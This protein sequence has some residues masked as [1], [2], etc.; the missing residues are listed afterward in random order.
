M[1]LTET[2]PAP[3]DTPPPA[4]STRLRKLVLAGLA[5]AVLVVFGILGFALWTNSKIDRLDA[6]ALPSLTPALGDGTRTFLVVGTDDRSD[7]PEDFA[8]VFGEFGGSRTDTI[9]LVNFTPGRGAEVIS[10]PRDLRVEIPGEGTNRINAAFSLGGPELLIATISD[11]LD[12]DVN[13]YVEIDLAGFAR[14]VDAIDGV[15]LLFEHDARDAKSGLAVTAGLQRL[16]GEQALAYVRS[17]QYQEFRNGEWQTVGGNDIGRTRRQQQ[18]LLNLFDQVSSKKNVFN[19][20][21]FASTFAEEVTV[22]AGLGLGVLVELGRAALD[23]STG[24][25]E[26]VTLPVLDHRGS[27]GRAYV[28]PSDDAASYLDAFRAGEPFAG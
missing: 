21:G 23:L 12:I 10:L 7:I 2:P 16:D 28:I 6:E 9:M 14:L 4:S 26:A 25:I 17:R 20:P 22:D 11:N 5:L 15:T 18:M 3:P 1:A 19:L 8:D 24:D 13:H 27:D